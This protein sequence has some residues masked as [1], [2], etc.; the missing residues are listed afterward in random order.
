MSE[1]GCSVVT[2]SC[3]VRSGTNGRRSST[4]FEGAKEPSHSAHVGQLAALINTWKIFEQYGT[5]IHTGYVFGPDAMQIGQGSLA[6]VEY[7][8]EC[9]TS[10]NSGSV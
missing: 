9:W 6:M 7:I 5:V 3:S 1:C 4:G 10:G 8:R 2:K